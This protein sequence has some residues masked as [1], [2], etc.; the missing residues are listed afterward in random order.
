MD[1]WGSYI[2][3]G[4]L[5]EGI[6]NEMIDGRF[7]NPRINMMFCVA[8]FRPGRRGPFVSAKGPK[9]IDAPSGLIRGDGRE[10]AES[11]PTRKAQTRPVGGWERPSLGPAGRRRP[12]KAKFQDLS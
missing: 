9:T 1:F 2:I 7:P 8:G 6:V 11:G 3:T 5:V 4:S 10:L 12:Q